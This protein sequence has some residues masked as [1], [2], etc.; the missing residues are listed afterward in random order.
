VLRATPPKY[1]A[2][3]ERPLDAVLDDI[4]R[5]A[6]LP[7]ENA[8]TLPPEAYTSEAFHQWEIEHV[9]KPEWQCV[10]HISQ[11]PNAGDFLSLDLLGEPLIV[12]NG[13]D[14]AIRV[15]SRTCPH[16]GM[17]IMPPGFGRDGHSIAEPAEDGALA[18]GHTRLFLCPY[19]SWTFEL[20]G[21]LKAC[22]EMHLAKGFQRD[23]WG[24]REF[25]SE[26]WH[27]FIFVN[28]DGTAEPLAPRLA[29]MDAD[30]GQ[31]NPAG[32]KV[33]LQ[34]EWDCPFNW[35]V[36]VENFM[37]SYHHLGAHAKTLQPM[38][39]ARDTWNEQ[40]RALFI[41]C[42]IPYKPSVLDELNLSAHPFGFPTITTLDESRKQ[43]GGLFLVYPNCLLFVLPDR[44]VWYR[45]SPE[46]PD[47]LRLLTT[48]LVPEETTRHPD[49]D[50][51]YA[52]QT[53]LMI[54]FHLEDMEMCTAIQRGMHSLG[55][56]RGRLSHLEMSVWLLQRYLA[57]RARDTWPTLDRPAAPSQRNH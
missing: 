1:S 12:V 2:R 5:T 29:E 8:I 55:A 18:S 21:K 43:E 42:H 20:D 30:F 35:K 13:K 39:P 33:V 31:W 25:R 3:A 23:E 44:V 14:G 51:M 40:E 9:F 54:E 46:G 4:Q 50:A 41:R 32:M 10:A 47:R 15:L 38:M 49:Y 37:E 45:I 17:D 36:L 19:H 16:R 7:L 56:Q 11:I 26:V 24:L 27:G 57:A 22:P 6:A 48:M 34:R 53:P 28:L 52:S